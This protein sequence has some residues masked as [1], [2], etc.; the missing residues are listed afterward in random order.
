MITHLGT[1]L[2]AVQQRSKGFEMR[3]LGK[4]THMRAC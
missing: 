2:K 4:Y 3:N 1:S